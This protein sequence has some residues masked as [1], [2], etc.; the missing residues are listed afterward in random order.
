M[1]RTTHTKKLLIGAL[2]ASLLCLGGYGYGVW[3][4]FDEITAVRDLESKV[5]VENAREDL[6][7]T[8]KS[9]LTQTQIERDKLSVLFLQENELVS[10]IEHIEGLGGVTNTDLEIQAVDVVAAEAEQE[11]YEWLKLTV[12]A[13]GA[14]GEVYHLLSLL[15]NVPLGVS[16]RTA[17]IRRDGGVLAEE[18]S[19][20]W[21]GRFDVFVLKKQ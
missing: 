6:D 21:A 10:F 19:E 15:E 20:E 7:R 1:E 5:Q 12:V 13:R 4:V 9:L 18:S 11:V 17:E 3:E 2:G 8:T 16:L 14:W